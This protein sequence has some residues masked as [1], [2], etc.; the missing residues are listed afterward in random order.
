MTTIS[1]PGLGIG[2]F[3]INP[4]AIPFGDSGAG[5]LVEDGNA[6]AFVEALLSL[7]R[8]EDLRLEM[9]EAARLRADFFSRENVSRLWFELLEE[10]D[11]AKYN[12]SS[13]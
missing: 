4:V 2:E 6:P 5:I 8:N 3:T 7:A 12:R 10:L 11:E 1:F 9:A 13:I